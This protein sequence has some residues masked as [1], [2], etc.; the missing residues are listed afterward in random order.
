[1]QGA[2]HVDPPMAGSVITLGAF[3]GVHRGHQALIDRAVAHGRRLGVPAVGYTFHPHPAV[4][5]APARAPALLLAVEERTRLMRAHGLDHV[6]VERFDADFAQVTA[7]AFVADY[8]VAPLA[9]KAIV[10]GFNFAYGKD[11]GGNL[12]HL[13]AAGERFGFEVDVV[14][15]VRIGGEVVSSTRVRGCL[16]EGDVAG[17]RRLLGRAPFVTGRVVK[18]DQRGRTIGFPTANVAPEAEL[19]PK[20]GVYATWVTLDGEAAP[21]PSVTNIGRR[22]TFDGQTVTVESFLLD[23]DGDLYGRRLEVALVARLRDERR[24]DGVEA[25]KAQLA[26]DVEAARAALAEGA[27][28]GLE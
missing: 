7:D 28:S 9:P 13:R 15:A 6:I 20:A 26:Q 5:L 27:G 2:R 22:P 16:R 3:D 4:T 12:D 25:L 14:D 23:F 8:L 24:F 1:M 18:G 11:R 19:I 10:V 21:R 17:A